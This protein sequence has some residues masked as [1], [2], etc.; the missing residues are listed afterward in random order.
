MD[1]ETSFG[2]FII[3]YGYEVK[4]ISDGNHFNLIFK[5]KQLK[6]KGKDITNSF[7]SKIFNEA[8]TYN[9]A[10][11]FAKI[12]KVKFKLRIFIICFIVF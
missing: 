3:K 5:I 2:N 11:N 4:P 1:N 7:A 12:N 8:D 10:N 9:F 6:Y